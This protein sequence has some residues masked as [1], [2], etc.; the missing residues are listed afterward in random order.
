MKSLAYGAIPLPDDGL[1]V[2]GSKKMIVS[3]K[4]ENQEC[5]NYELKDRICFFSY[6]TSR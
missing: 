3:K 4:V 5:Q 2:G 6:T 1:R